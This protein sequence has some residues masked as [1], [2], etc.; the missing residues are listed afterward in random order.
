M[1]VSE[2]S[3]SSGFETPTIPGVGTELVDIVREANG[4]SSVVGVDRSAESVDSILFSNCSLSGEWS[5]AI[6][7]GQSVHAAGHIADNGEGDVLV[8]WNEYPDSGCAA[9]PHV[10]LRNA[11]GA[12]K[13][14]GP[15]PGA[16]PGETRVGPGALTKNGMGVVLW[17]PLDPEVSQF[18]CVLS[19]AS[20]SWFAPDG[21][22]LSTTLLDADTASAKDVQIAMTS[23]GRT[24]VAWHHTNALLVRWI[25]P[26]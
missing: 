18:D 14:L 6:A 17:Y 4:S 5:D 15:I 25:D 26:L 9:S 19:P 8:T 20:L 21:T 13:T 1:T 7:I 24:L 3:S 16:V 23:S 11:A 2:F 12:W 10:L 22:W